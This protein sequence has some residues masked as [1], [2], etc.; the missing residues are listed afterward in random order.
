MPDRDRPVEARALRPLAPP[1]DHELR[2]P[3]EQP[4]RRGLGPLSDKL[5]AAAGQ[6][7]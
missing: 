4:D 3:V 7:S 6:R 1:Q 2:E 5:W